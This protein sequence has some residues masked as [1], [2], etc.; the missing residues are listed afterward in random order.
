LSG[1]EIQNLVLGQEITMDEFGRTYWVDHSRKGI[2]R[3]LSRLR[4]GKWWIEGDMLCYK[5]DSYKLY[6]E[7]VENIFP[8]IKGLNDCG[9]I[10]RNPDRL[11]G[12]SKQYLYVKDYS[13]AALTTK[14]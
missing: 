4:E 3:D 13:I 11:P 9:E 8:T 5:L 7:S 10:Y 6:S 14:K 12:S 1:E 2:L